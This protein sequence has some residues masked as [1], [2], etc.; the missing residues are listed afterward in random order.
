M[1]LRAELRENRWLRAQLA[2]LI[3]VAVWM[4]TMVVLVAS[5]VVAL[6]PTAVLATAG[7]VCWVGAHRTQEAQLAAKQREAADTRALRTPRAPN[8]GPDQCPVCGGYGLNDLAADDVFMERGPDR[9][10]VVPYGRRRAHWDCA[11]FVPYVAPPIPHF[12]AFA[13]D[14]HEVSCDCPRCRTTSDRPGA[15]SRCKFCGFYRWAPSMDAAKEKLIAH[16][17]VCLKRPQPPGP[18]APG[19]PVT[20]GKLRASLSDALDAE[21]RAVDAKLRKAQADL[22]WLSADLKGWRD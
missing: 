20:S 2:L 3:V 11:E 16:S 12:A 9:C 8:A 7:G 21:V 15:Y 22:A 14:G 19:G 10:K 6:L 4:P 17:K 5:P 13:I 18:F 1:T